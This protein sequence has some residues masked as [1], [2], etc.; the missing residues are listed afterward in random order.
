[1]IEIYF[2]ESIGSVQ[3]M[4][5][6]E[7]N[8]DG[9]LKNIKKNYSDIFSLIAIERNNI[10]QVKPFI[11]LFINNIMSVE[12]NP[13]LKAGDRLTIEVAISGG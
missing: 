11:T 2:P 1:M 7:N 5:V 4:K 9:V 13:A 8:L 12:S 6:E 10:C 3:Q